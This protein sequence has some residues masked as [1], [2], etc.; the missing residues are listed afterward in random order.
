MLSGL[1][2][3]THLSTVGML[4]S[5]KPSCH[6]TERKADELRDISK[7]PK[8]RRNTIALSGNEVQ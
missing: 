5:E 6:V 8:G 1:P 7:V 2:L 4:I 3:P